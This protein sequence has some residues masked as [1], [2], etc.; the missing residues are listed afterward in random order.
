MSDET[1]EDLTTQIDAARELLTEQGLNVL[2]SEAM[3]KRLAREKAPLERDLKALQEQM[4]KLN[5][6]NAELKA[7]RKEIED[8][9]KTE[10]ELWESRQKEWEKADQQRQSELEKAMSELESERARNK[11]FRVNLKLRDMLT[12]AINPEIA[13]MWASQKL[14]GLSVSDS[15]DLVYTEPTGV[16]HEGLAAEKIVS[17]WWAAQTDLQVAKA[18][19]PDTRGNSKAPP[20]QNNEYQP[21]PPDTDLSARLEHAKQHNPVK[22]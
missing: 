2:D 22:Y 5:A 14:Q 12:D 20:P 7:Y 16:A 8:K 17:D 4:E 18:P 3:G 10:L 15:G 19:G 13:L 1:T 21:L 6:S 9:D 11:E